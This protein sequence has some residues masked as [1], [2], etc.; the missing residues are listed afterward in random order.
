MKMEINNMWKGGKSMNVWKLNTPLI[1]SQQVKGEI[2]REIKEY[3]NTS[4]NGNTTWK[5]KH[6]MKTKIYGMLQKQFR[7]KFIELNL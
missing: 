1:N 5:S 3:L 4:E 2:K 6:K 7:G